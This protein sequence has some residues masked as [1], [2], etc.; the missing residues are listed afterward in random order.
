MEFIL[1]CRVVFFEELRGVGI[2]LHAMPAKFS[3]IN[4]K[5]PI[6]TDEDLLDVTSDYVNLS[7]AAPREIYIFDMETIDKFSKHEHS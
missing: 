4:D 5:L 1:R 3:D 6:L 7:T 2:E